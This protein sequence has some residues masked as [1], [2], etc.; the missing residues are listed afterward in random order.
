M[1]LI[2][3]N[4]DVNLIIFSQFWGAFS[5]NCWK[6]PWYSTKLVDD[7][8]LRIDI[9]AISESLLRN[10]VSEIR[11]CPVKIHLADCMTK[12]GSSGYNVL[13][14]FKEGQMPEDFILK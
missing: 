7:K 10:E 4:F 5:Q 2:S 3:P 11:W 9:A 6:R 14:V 13:N 1:S 8:R 12:R